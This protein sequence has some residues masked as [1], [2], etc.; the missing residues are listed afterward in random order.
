MASMLPAPDG[1]LIYNTDSS[2]FY[3]FNGNIEGWQNL[4][5]GTDTIRFIC[6]ASFQDSRDGHIY[7]TVQIG[8]QCWMAENLSAAKYRN[9]DV[10]PN[11]TNQEEWN[12]LTT[13]AYAWYNNDSA[14]YE[15]LYGKLYNWYAVGDTRDLC[16]IGWHVPTSTEWQILE[17]TV[18]SQYGIDDPEWNIFCEWRGY[19]AGLNLKSTNGWNENGNG[20]DL[21]GFS[22]LPGGLRTDMYFAY[23]G[24]YSN[25]WGDQ[26]SLY[27]AYYDRLGYDSTNV[28][29]C[30]YWKWWGLSVRCI[31]D[32]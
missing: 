19:D 12:P 14:T 27:Y 30:E 20:T 5:P 28:F 22:G 29:Q 17:G 31:K 13:G 9:G 18:D 16:P 32:E 25:W 4:T 2:Q 7:N 23:M 8:T 24:I 1:L 15:D 11:V 26:H 6:G 3:Y 10:I 21:F